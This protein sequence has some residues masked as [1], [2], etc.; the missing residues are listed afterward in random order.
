MVKI[1][2]VVLL[3]FVIFNLF[4]ALLAMNNNDQTRQMSK[5]LGLRLMYSVAI[6]A[7]ILI[8]AQ[9][10]WITPNQRPY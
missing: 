4:K 7:F 9:L 8:A 1:I 5:R 3:I 10:G 2:I 6:I